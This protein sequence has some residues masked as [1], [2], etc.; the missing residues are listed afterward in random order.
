MD[1][2][3]FLFWPI[4]FAFL[5]VAFLF[6]FQPRP[7]HAS[8]VK[9]FIKQLR[10]GKKA[11]NAV[12][13]LRAHGSRAVAELT[14]C[15]QNDSDIAVRGWAIVALRGISGSEADEALRRLQDDSRLDP[16]INTWAAAARIERA[17]DTDSLMDLAPLQ[18]RF[19]AL[20]RPLGL[21][22][23]ALLAQKGTVTMVRLLRYSLDVPSFAS[24]L[25]QPILKDGPKPLMRNLLWGQ[26]DTRRQ[27]ATYL[28]TLA[29]RG[30][31]TAVARA[32]VD[33]YRFYP[34]ARS[35]PWEGGSLFLPSINWSRKEARELVGHLIAWMVFC[36]RRGR[37]DGILQIHNNITSL[38][39]SRTV[40]YRSPGRGGADPIEW[41]KIWRTV[42]GANGIKNILQAQEV[43]KEPRYM[44]VQY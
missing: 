30:E 12:R 39:L 44:R 28:A 14:Q 6:T 5:A 26:D 7:A 35:I 17:Q 36:D 27:A 15:A 11:E 43:D 1:S 41:L 19:P 16:L 29:H 38:E 24:A 33:A 23:E 4:A 20:K 42:V 40:G 9:A 37:P 34:R 25:A 22:L 32:T 18:R 10:D 13:I 8:T 2:K 3:R 31:T 21:R